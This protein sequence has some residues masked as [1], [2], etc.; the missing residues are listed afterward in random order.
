MY[1]SPLSWILFGIITGIISNMMDPNPQENSIFSS[2]L[3]GVGGAVLGGFLASAVLG[4]TVGGFNLTSFLLAMVGSL[5][6]VIVSRTF[7]HV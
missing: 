4:G 7:R 5:A 2:L 1:M 6:L 3:M